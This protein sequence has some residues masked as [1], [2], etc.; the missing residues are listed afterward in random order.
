[1]K[2]VIPILIVLLLVSSG[3]VGMSIIPSTGT[4]VGEKTY[5]V[6]FE[7]N[8]LYVGGSGP[9]NYSSIQAAINDAENDDTVFVFDDSSPYYEHVKVDKTI[10]LIGEKYET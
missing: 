5:T 2:H 10:N 6:S 7:G 8:T 4:N 1:M 9:G 3:F